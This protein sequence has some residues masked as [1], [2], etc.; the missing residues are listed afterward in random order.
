MSDEKYMV[1]ANPYVTPDFLSGG[2]ITKI[3]EDNYTLDDSLRRA[4]LNNGIYSN[5]VE[6]KKALN[7][8]IEDEIILFSKI[9]TLTPEELYDLCEGE[10]NVT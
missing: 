9:I 2:W 3:D 8:F 10:K 4:A 7:W 1:Y 5:I 6:V